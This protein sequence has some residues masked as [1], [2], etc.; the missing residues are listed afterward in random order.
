MRSRILKIV[1]TNEPKVIFLD[2]FTY[3]NLVNFTINILP[4]LKHKF[5]LVIAGNDYMTPSGQFE[6]NI[7]FT[8]TNRHRQNGVVEKANNRIGSLILKYQAENE[9]LTKK[10][11]TSKNAKV[12]SV[13]DTEGRT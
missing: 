5:V 2:T 3:K 6:T 1:D 8:L 13:N 4:Y 7:K 10:K 11:M 9:I 12:P